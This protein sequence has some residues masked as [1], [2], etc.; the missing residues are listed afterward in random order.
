[1]AV[2]YGAAIAAAGTGQSTVDEK[3][4]AILAGD[5][6]TIE[7][8]SEDE[9]VINATFGPGSGYA[10]ESLVEGTIAALHGSLPEGL[11]VAVTRAAG[12]FDQTF[13]VNPDGT[14][15]LSGLVSELD[16]DPYAYQFLAGGQPVGEPGTFDAAIRNARA[17]GVALSRSYFIETVTDAGGRELVELM[18]QGQ[19][20]PI[21]RDYE[22]ATTN[23]YFA[24]L[25]FFE[26][27]DFLKQVSIT[28]PTPVP[29]GT[30]VKLSLACDRQSRFSARAEVAGVVVDTQFE[31]SP[32]PPLPEASDVDKVLRET[33]AKIEQIPDPGKRIVAQ[34][35]LDRLANEVD[36]ALDEADSGKARD[37]LNE[38]RK[39]GSAAPTTG[40]LKPSAEQFE[41]LVTRCQA[42]NESSD[43]GGPQ[44]AEEIQALANAGRSA[45][46]DNNQSRLTQAVDG[47]E[48][49]HEQLT[50]TDTGGSGGGGGGGDRPPLWILCQVFGPQVLDTINE[51]DA[52]T[53]LPEQFRR[54]HMSTMDDDRAKIRQAVQATKPPLPMEMM[55]PDWMSDQDAAPHFSVIT[56]LYQRWNQIAEMTGGI[57]KR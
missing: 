36:S 27:G 9:L 40:A 50:T 43:H 15:V 34:K 30:A 1:M 29:P 42:A 5:T 2:G 28:F 26:E 55:P 24:E 17:V 37:K 32:P 31:S 14:F 23:S 16:P 6:E 20:L 39:L 33:R 38:V 35:Q 44:E 41:A 25:R 53:D 54:D 19:E 18:R 3:A 56:G 4:A 51:A 46:A 57:A 7:Q 22:F 21:S 12:G 11:T 8:L 45:Y 10:G 52:R 13:P 47:L 48:K 49:I